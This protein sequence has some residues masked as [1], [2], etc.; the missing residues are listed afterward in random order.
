MKK[1]VFNVCQLFLLSQ[2][3]EHIC[4]RNKEDF[5]GAEMPD[6]ETLKSKFS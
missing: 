5:M 4:N 6:I 3:A 1:L 2:T